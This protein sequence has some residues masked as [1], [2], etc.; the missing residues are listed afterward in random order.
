MRK[1][2]IYFFLALLVAGCR[3]RYELPLRETDVSLL[4]VEGVLNAGQGR[5]TI[6]LSRTVKLNDSATIKPVL[7]AALTVESKSGTSYALTEMGNG[8]YIHTQL[9]LT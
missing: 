8:Q 9:P 7:G 2:K 1:L 3:D 5:T 4:V 6:R